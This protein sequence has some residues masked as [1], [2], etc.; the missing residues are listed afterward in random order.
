[1]DPNIAL[2]EE[3]K[4]DYDPKHFY[5][6]KLGEVFADA[7][8][9]ITKLGYGG[10]STVWLAK[11]VRRRLW[12]STRYVVLK[13]CN[14]DYDNQV[15]SHELRISD[16][17]ATTKPS[18]LGRQFLRTVIDSFMTKGPHGKHMCLVFEPLREPIWLLQRRFDDGRYPPGILKFTLRYILSGLHY[19]HSECHVIH[20]DLKPENILVGLESLSVLDNVA[21]TEIA[22]PSPRKV[23]HDRIIYLSRNDFGPP[24]SSPG[25]PMITDFGSAAFGNTLLPLTHCIQPN[26]YRSPEVILGAPWSYSTDIWNLGVMIWNLLEDKTLCNGLDPDSSAYSSRAHLGQLVGFIGDPPKELLDRGELSTRWF[27]D[28]GVF[29][30]QNFVSRGLSL[31]D[32]VTTLDGEDKRLFLEFVGKMLQWLPENRSTA[33]ELLVHP[34]LHWFP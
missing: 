2:E 16:H 3:R 4:D 15:S 13:I 18:H 21:K 29:K 20:T 5:P 23:L 6:V 27:S 17:I 28:K 25:K 30:Y 33:K 11:D 10:S 1:M 19:L 7:Y 12:P 31:A 22:E 8:Q 9:V 32:T 34:W 24:K 14:N 26:P